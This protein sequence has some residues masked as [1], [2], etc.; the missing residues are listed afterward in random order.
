MLA[1]KYLGANYA[2][3]NSI[4]WYFIIFK[5]DF[6]LLGKGIAMETRKVFVTFIMI[7]TVIWSET[8]A[9][10][11]PMYYIQPLYISLLFIQL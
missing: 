10:V 1:V 5:K 2:E 6:P 7:S 11:N 3:G 9:L 4:K 8:Y